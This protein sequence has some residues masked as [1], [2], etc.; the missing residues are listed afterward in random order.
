LLEAMASIENLLG[1]EAEMPAEAVS[2]RPHR[3]G[4]MGWIVHRQMVI[5]AQE[6]GWNEEYEALASEITAKFLRHFDAARERCWIAESGGAIAGSVFLVRET[7]RV[8]KLRLLYVEPWARGRG[9]GRLL[10]DQ[11][12]RFA[13]EA[14]YRT[15]RLWTNSVLLAA[16]SVYEKAGFQLVSEQAHHSFGHDLTGQIW[17]RTL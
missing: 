5:Y 17:E 12:I 16:R 2:L 14:G 13:A 3:P 4:D 1:A 9:I 10:T 6:Y 7:A 8:A 11:C 15:I